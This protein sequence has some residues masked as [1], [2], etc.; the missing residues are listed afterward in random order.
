MLGMIEYVKF[1]TVSHTLQTTLSEDI[2][3]IK[4]SNSMYIPAD[5]TRNLYKMD[6]DE[7]DKLLRENITKTYKSTNTSTVVSINAEA[8]KRRESTP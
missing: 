8:Q 1:R 7:H 5:K 3:M 2:K 4:S 6:P